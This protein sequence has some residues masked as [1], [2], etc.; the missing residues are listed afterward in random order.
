MLV[1]VIS[2]Q[3][4]CMLDGVFACCH[5]FLHFSW[6]LMNWTELNPR[7]DAASTGFKAAVL[8]QIH[9]GH[10]FRI[11]QGAASRKRKWWWRKVMH[12]SCANTKTKNMSWSSSVNCSGSF[13]P[14][15]WQE[16]PSSP[17]KARAPKSS[18][19][20][21]SASATAC[22]GMTASQT[23]FSAPPSD[24]QKYL[25]FSAVEEVSALSNTFCPSRYAFLHTASGWEF[26]QQHNV[27]LSTQSMH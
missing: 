9:Q 25:I 16:K 10:P 7:K 24:K 14:G 27:F 12:K 4:L 5:T 13:P 26:C 6:F 3:M 8:Y 15:W 19:H 21:S 17:R 22:T 1:T 11:R 2:L 20:L 23:A 18:I